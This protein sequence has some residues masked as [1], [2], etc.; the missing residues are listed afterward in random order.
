[1]T[2]EKSSDWFLIDNSFR[3]SD[4]PK[5]EFITLSTKC[6]E[7]VVY[8]KNWKRNIEYPWEYEISEYVIHCIQKGWKLSFSIK[9]LAGTKN[10]ALIADESAFEDEDFVNNIS[11]WILAEK[12]FEETMQ[13]MEIEWRTYVLQDM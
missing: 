7:D 2:I 8:D 12:S 11:D 1:M 9:T 13:K 6:G 5:N 3:Y 10:F 4:L